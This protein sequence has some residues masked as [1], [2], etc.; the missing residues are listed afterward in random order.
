MP[1]LLITITWELGLQSVDSLAL[2]VIS[3]ARYPEVVIDWNPMP[4]AHIDWVCALLYQGLAAVWQT[5]A[6]LLTL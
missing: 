2:T 4:V 1:C 6:Y 3:G 5:F